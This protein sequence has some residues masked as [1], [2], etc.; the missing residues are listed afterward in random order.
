M[1]SPN[2]AAFCSTAE[3]SV[4]RYSERSTLPEEAAKAYI[5]R[6]FGDIWF[7]VDENA[8]QTILE[9]TCMKIKPFSSIKISVFIIRP[10]LSEAAIVRSKKFG[11]DSLH[12]AEVNTMFV[13]HTECTHIQ[14]HI[15]PLTVLIF[16][17]NRNCPKW[18]GMW[19]CMECPSRQPGRPAVAIRRRTH[20]RQLR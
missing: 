17:R 12:F 14:S 19:P 16:R 3:Y 18:C 15:E 4:Q 13:Q 20:A 2:E 10:Q 8:V 9:T 5:T 1:I 6:I 7:S 11:I